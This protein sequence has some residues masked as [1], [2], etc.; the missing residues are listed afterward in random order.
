MKTQKRKNATKKLVTLFL[1]LCLIASVFSLYGCVLPDATTMD[2]IVGTYE[3]TER[4]Y[5]LDE[6][7]QK[8]D[9]K[10]RDE[11]EAYLVINENGRG[12]RIYKDKDTPFYCVEIKLVFNPNDE[13]PGKYK[14]VE[15]YLAPNA[16][17]ITL[18]VKG[19]SQE[20]QYSNEQ[21]QL[22]SHI[23][24]KANTITYK[25]V[26]SVDNLSYVEEKL[27][28]KFSYEKFEL[29]SSAGLHCASDVL[30]STLNNVDDIESEYIYYF[31]NLKE[32]GAKQDGS[33]LYSADIYYALKSD[34]TAVKKAAVNTAYEILPDGTAK[35]VIDGAT[36]IK[37]NGSLVQ[38][39]N[40]DGS[41]YEL[42]FYDYG[43]PEGGEEGIETEAASRIAKYIENHPE[44]PE[45][46]ENPEN[47]EGENE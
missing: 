11:I 23:T 41:I 17:P 4:L 19:G 3:L 37:K 30:N 36:Y 34:K 39:V 46:P 21:W 20:L 45:N 12:Y 2:N 43:M 10:T 18:T 22:G 40:V 47:P 24:I 25:R 42:W 15:T 16:N 32:A 13:D 6:N 28:Q 14:Q 38:Q 8:I 27:G 29:L 31:V 44:T 26:S 1:T 9:I 33:V 7:G 5:G 35:F